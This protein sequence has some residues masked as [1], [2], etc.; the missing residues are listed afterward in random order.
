MPLTP[1]LQSARSR[2]TILGINPLLPQLEKSA[3]FFAALLS[4]NPGLRLTILYESDS[5]NF[6]QA[7]STD[8]AFFLKAH[9]DR[10]DHRDRIDS[11]DFQIQGLEDGIKAAAAAATACEKPLQEK[12]TDRVIIRQFNLR[13]PVNIIRVDERLWYCVTTHTSPSISSYMEVF[14]ES[15]LYEELLSYLDFVTDSGRGGIYLS[16]PGEELIEVYDHIGIPR[17]IL[18]RK[19]F[20]TTDFRGYAVW[21]FVFNR[22]GE[23]LLHQRSRQTKDNQLL[24]DKSVGGHVDLGERDTSI[25][26]RREL[27]E[28]LFL[29]EAEFT[30]PLYAERVKAEMGD[31]L[32][33]GEWDPRKKPEKLFGSTFKELDPSDWVLFRATDEKGEPLTISIISN[34]KIRTAGTKAE[35]AD[36]KTEEVVTKQTRYFIDLFFVISPEGC[37]DTAGQMKKQLGFSEK[38]GAAE[39]HKLASVPELGKLIEEAEKKGVRGETFTDDLLYIYSEHREMLE[40]FSEFVRAVFR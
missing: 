21:I 36:R 11:P 27:V 10:I 28:E 3:G 34:R 1:F 40:R 37:L 33:F 38:T 30:D 26:A 15:S 2:I 20:Y 16:E 7:L 25:T 22:R 32:N 39:D 6:F 23:L 29:P 5:E 19:A 17:G 12:I 35:E 4:E 18:P 13:L 9:K 31:I 24:W 8:S 14:P